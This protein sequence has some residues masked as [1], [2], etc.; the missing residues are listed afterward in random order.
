LEDDY[1]AVL[2]ILLRAPFHVSQRCVDELF[3][4]AV[5]LPGNMDLYGTRLAPANADQAAEAVA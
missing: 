4:G 1:R 5:A 2:G 3:A